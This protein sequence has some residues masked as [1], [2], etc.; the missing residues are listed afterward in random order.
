MA[1]TNA[2]LAAVVLDS[3]AQSGLEF[4]LL[5]NEEAVATGTVASDL[6]VVVGLRPEAAIE[7]ASPFLEAA[8]LRPIMV[9]D[10]DVGATA[11][12]FLATHDASEGVQLDLM[13]DPA[14]RGKYG[15]KTV[16]MLASSFPGVRW[17]HVGPAHRTAYLIR[18]RFVKQDA[19][20]LRRQITEAGQFASVDFSAV[21]RETFSRPVANSVL[22][23][24]GGRGLSSHVPYPAAYGA[25]NLMRRLR[26]VVRP[27]GFWVEISGQS[28]IEVAEGVANRFLRF[29]P[30]V[31]ATERPRG[32]LAQ[33]GWFLSRVFPVRWRAGVVVSAGSGR[34]RG[35]LQLEA[36]VGVDEVCSRVVDAMSRR[37]NR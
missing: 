28:A 12:F 6:D 13:Y 36:A 33:V 10:Y 23:L 31:A 7:Q 1:T 30:V 24:V 8:G 18:K 15:A 34:P 2:R 25:R 14:G 19:I 9:W 22:E 16:P 35:D 37:V 11:T 20:G 4:A 21:V 26:R 27:T 17:P 29:L 32:Q 5:H 3:L